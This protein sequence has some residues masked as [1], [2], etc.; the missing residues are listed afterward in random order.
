MTRSETFRSL[1]P[2]WP[3]ELGDDVA[4]RRLI[5]ARLEDACC[6]ER[7]RGLVGHWTYSLPRHDRML[8]LLTRE[9]DALADAELRCRDARIIELLRVTAVERDLAQ[10]ALYVASRELE[11][12]EA[13]IADLRGASERTL[14]AA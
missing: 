2:V 5:V 7:R 11:R 9:R 4:S 14:E 8:R 12:L 6:G 13:Q 1:L 3:H 10:E